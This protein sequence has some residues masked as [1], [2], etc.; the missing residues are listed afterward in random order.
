ML[1]RATI[2][3]TGTTP[4][5]G[6]RAPSGSCTGSAAAL[7]SPTT[8]GGPATAPT[9]AAILNGLSLDARINVVTW[10]LD[11]LDSLADKPFDILQKL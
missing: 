4:R 6:S 11:L 3:V 10:Q 7:G 8:T 2:A 5:T 9:A 1:T